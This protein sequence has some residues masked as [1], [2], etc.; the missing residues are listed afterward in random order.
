MLLNVLLSFL[1]HFTALPD[2]S[3][4]VKDT[5]SAPGELSLKVTQNQTPLFVKEIN[6]EGNKRTKSFIIVRELAF[7][8]FDSIPAGK[9]AEYILQ[10]KNNVYNLALFNFV[11]FD[12]TIQN[13]EVSFKIK[14]VERWHIWPIPQI[15]FADPNFNTWYETKDLSRI[16][17]GLNTRWSNFLG[18][19]QTV[20]FFIQMGYTRQAQIKYDVPQIDKRQ[21]L[22]MSFSTAYSNNKEI[23]YATK[24][25]KRLF[26][27]DNSKYVREEV[28][29]EIKM[30]YRNRIFNSHELRLKY[31]YVQIDDT[32]R[33]LKND[34]LPNNLTYS[35]YLT[36]EYNYRF[37]RRDLKFYPLKGYFIEI[38]GT[39]V[40]LF[41][42]NN[43]PD[44]AY[45]TTSLRYYKDLG[46]RFYFASGGKLKL[47]SVLNQPYYIQQGLGN[48]NLKTS[49]D[50]M[51]GY[52]YYIIDGQSWGFVK[53]NFKFNL[54]KP[55]VYDISMLPVPQ[56]SKNVFFAS[57]INI[58]FD[59]GYVTDRVFNAEN[60][61]AN[62]Y[63]YSYGVG[64]DFVGSFDFVL[65]IEYS[66]N[67][68]KE[69]GF[70]LNFIAPI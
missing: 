45:L 1:V 66:I 32:I 24:N 56:S 36:L 25:N 5:L 52:E 42:F 18:K 43:S 10:S 53:S 8:Q 37:D 26:L 49:Y 50:I 23:V 60:T 17:F 39:K 38:T 9:L 4:T 44:F 41:N 30:I 29:S 35:N 14:V 68:L 65:R 34:Y 63:L 2:T 48:A 19:N 6:I 3:K 22:G 57:Y 51:R 12:Y 55:R 7:K 64:V 27:F 11:N 70:F 16:N 59:Q 15:T 67:K 31:N 13:Q 61:L 62:Q 20:R 40:G 46:K 33:F 58:F 69:N 54:I 21:K 47:G 28:G